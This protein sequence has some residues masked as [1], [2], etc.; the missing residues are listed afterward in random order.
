MVREGVIT[1][2]LWEILE[3]LLPPRT[4]R[5][6]RPWNDHRV[7]LEGIAWRFR[8]DAPWRDVPAGFGKYQS[9]WERHRLWSADGTYQRMLEAVHAAVGTAPAAGWLNV[10]SVDSTVVRADQHAAGARFHDEGFR[11]EGNEPGHGSS[12]EVTGQDRGG[13][14]ESQ[15]EARRAG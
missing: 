5:Q 4:G 6:G 14:V 2:E 13:W 1:D 11:D 9:V 15:E 7:T 12:D 10:L 8:V 3:P